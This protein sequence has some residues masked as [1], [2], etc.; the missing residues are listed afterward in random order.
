MCEEERESIRFRIRSNL[1]RVRTTADY[2][3]KREIEMNLIY[4]CRQT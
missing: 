4:F 2:Q 3:R 1:R